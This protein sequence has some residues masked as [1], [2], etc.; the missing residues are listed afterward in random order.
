MSEDEDEGMIMSMRHVLC[1]RLK[2]IN[3]K[4]QNQSGGL[5]SNL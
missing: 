4:F 5:R 3:A 1:D 2:V